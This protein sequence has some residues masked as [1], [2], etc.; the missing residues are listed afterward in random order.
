MFVLIHGDRVNIKAEGLPFAAISLTHRDREIADSELRKNAKYWISHPSQ[1]FWQLYKALDEIVQL[2]TVSDTGELIF[3]DEAFET[4]QFVYKSQ[5]VP[6]IFLR[7]IEHI[8]SEN[9]TLPFPF[10]D[11]VLETVAAA[12]QFCDRP[13]LNEG[14]SRWKKSLSKSM[15]LIDENRF[16]VP[17]LD[18]PDWDRDSRTLSFRGSNRIFAVQ[19]GDNVKRILDVFQ[20]FGWRKAEDNPLSEDEAKAALRTLNTSNLP[21]CF[22]KDGD[23]ICWQEK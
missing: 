22:S 2:G 3:S 17:S 14:L 16:N 13:K 15:H 10:D 7:R 12:A 18:T 1:M 9:A 11:T 6:R 19:T 8:R 21:L 4:G 5:F 23:R 20:E